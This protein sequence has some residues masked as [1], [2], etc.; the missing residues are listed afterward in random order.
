MAQT[1]SGW[2]GWYVA[3][4]A[5]STSNIFQGDDAR[6]VPDCHLAIPLY[7]AHQVVATLGEKLSPGFVNLVNDWGVHGGVSPG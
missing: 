3:A 4:A 2:D 5:F 6:R 1:S 7:Q